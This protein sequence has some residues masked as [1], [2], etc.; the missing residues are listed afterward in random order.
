MQSLNWSIDEEFYNNLN[1]RDKRGFQ[2]I[3]SNL[4][5]NMENFTN[6]H[7]LR[8]DLLSSKYTMIMISIEMTV[9]RTTGNRKSE[10]ESER[11]KRG[12]KERK[13]EF[14]RL[15]KSIHNVRN[16]TRITN[17]PGWQEIATMN[18]RVENK[19]RLWKEKRKRLQN[20]T[21]TL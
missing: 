3:K 19:E 11:D 16:K 20:Y 7:R 12:D 6:F 13:R 21:V 4:A 1:R 17:L 8:T 2:L 15:R 5:Y 10:W 14:A 9:V 18:R